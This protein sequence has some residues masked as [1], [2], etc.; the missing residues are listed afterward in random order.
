MPRGPAEA[1]PWAAV[2]MHVRWV[3]RMRRANSFRTG[4]EHRRAGGGHNPVWQCQRRRSGAGRKAS[5]SDAIGDERSR[6]CEGYR[7]S[8]GPLE[9][10]MRL[11]PSSQHTLPVVRTR[12]P[13]HRWRCNGGRGNGSDRSGRGSRGTRCAVVQGMAW[14]VPRVRGVCERWRRSE[15]RPSFRRRREQR[16]LEPQSGRRWIPA[17]ARMTAESGIF[18]G[19]LCVSRA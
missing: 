17:F 10:G 18:S 13:G 15:G 2:R 5:K 19:R 12:L 1:D 6:G 7:H 11:T 14:R 3:L 16:H 8:A 4:P 9:A